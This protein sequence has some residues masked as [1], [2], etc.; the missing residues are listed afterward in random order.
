[1]ALAYSDEGLQ[2]QQGRKW[3]TRGLRRL[4][5]SRDGSRVL[6]RRREHTGGPGRWRRG[7]GY[8]ARSPMSA[9]RGK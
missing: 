9:S 8:T 6:E 4:V 7:H 5:T 1:V 2:E 3:E